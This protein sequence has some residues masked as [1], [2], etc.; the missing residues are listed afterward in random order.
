[1]LIKKL[2]YSGVPITRAGF[3][4][5]AG[6]NFHEI[7]INEQALIR[8]S[9][10]EKLEFFLANKLAGR[11]FHE[12]YINEQALIRASRLEKTEIFSWRACSRNRDTRV[13]KQNA[14]S[15]KSSLRAEMSLEQILH[16]NFQ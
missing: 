10:L 3:N 14:V 16:S 5:R 12:I 8:A 11:N 4:K 2:N 9:R 7:F 15:A 13:L 6:R 1:M